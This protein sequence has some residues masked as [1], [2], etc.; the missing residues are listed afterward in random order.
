MSFP[1]RFRK[2]LKTTG[3]SGERFFRGPRA[4]QS[5]RL[6]GQLGGVSLLA[7]DGGGPDPAV[8]VAVFAVSPSD[9]PAAVER[10]RVMT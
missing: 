1:E 7:V 6:P 9:E 10:R 3:K 8:D 2:R 4:C 5:G